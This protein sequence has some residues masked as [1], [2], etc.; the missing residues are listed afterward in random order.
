MNGPS[1][2]ERLLATDPRDAGCGETFAVIGVFAE[3]V[4]GRGDAAAR[5]PGVPAHLAACP[6]CSQDL[7]GI[8]AAADCGPPGPG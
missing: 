4:T 2:I 3:S 5:F 1:A 8:V 6:S 7:Q